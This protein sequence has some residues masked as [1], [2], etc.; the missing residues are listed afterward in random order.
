MTARLKNLAWWVAFTATL[1]ML[2]H[3]TAAHHA[4]THPH[5]RGVISGCPVVRST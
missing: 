2:D 5:P 3:V 1:V 4:T